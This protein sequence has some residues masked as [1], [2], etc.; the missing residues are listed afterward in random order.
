MKA[1]LHFVGFFVALLAPTVLFFLATRPIKTQP[2]PTPPVD[3]SA[4]VS[5]K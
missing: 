3:G 2:I 4:P 5:T 1:A